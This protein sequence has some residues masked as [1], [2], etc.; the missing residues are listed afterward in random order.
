MFFIKYLHVFCLQ[1]E[2]D[3]TTSKSSKKT[4]N[5]HNISMM[6]SMP[7]SPAPQTMTLMSAPVGQTTQLPSITVPYPGQHGQPSQPMFVKVI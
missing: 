1:A 2:K 5:G 7:A 4:P 3:R 6:S